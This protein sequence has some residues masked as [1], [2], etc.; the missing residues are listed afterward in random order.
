M[1]FSDRKPNYEKHPVKPLGGRPGTLFAGYAAIVDEIRRRIADKPDPVVV[2]DMYHGTRLDEVVE[3]IVEPLCPAAS[4]FCED[5]KLDEE[6]LW[7]KI[8]RDVTD[9]RVFGS[10]STHVMDDFYDQ[11]ALEDMRGRLAAAKGLRVVYGVGASLVTRGDV[12]VYCDLTRW[13]I[14]LRYRSGE[15]D[16]WGVGNFQDDILRK[17]KRGFFLEWRVM[18]R[19]KVSI[20]DDVDLWVDTNAENDPKAADAT[21]MASALDEFA[22]EP[23]RLIPYFDAGIWGGHWMEEVCD[24]PAA[25]NNYAW[26]FDGV[27]EENSIAFEKG[28]ITFE[29]PAMN[30]VKMRPHALLGEKVFSRF[31]AEF[32]IRFDFL[33]TMGGGEPLSAST[34]EHRVHS[35]ELRHA[36]HAGRELLHP[37]CRRGRPCLPRRQERRRARRADRR[38]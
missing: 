37:R 18:D 22:N 4:F 17:Y 5:C 11:D 7:P 29:M 26:C 2:I 25:D 27:P 1:Y 21:A 30:L 23:F 38:A 6:Q 16:N 15:L 32:P 34:P 9:D 8:E 10:L 20:F 36:L 33:D 24:L 12:L 31:G 13:E 28:G 35:A 3:G 19:H 14:Q